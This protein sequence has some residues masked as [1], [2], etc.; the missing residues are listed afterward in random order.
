M[1]R[2]GGAATS[3]LP[4]STRPIWRAC[5]SPPTTIREASVRATSQRLRAGPPALNQMLSADGKRASG[6]SRQDPRRRSRSPS[7]SGAVSSADAASPS[8][9]R[10]DGIRVPPD[11]YSQAAK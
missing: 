1:V 10:R 3:G 5:P 11:K 4:R 7:V 2:V 8:G 9:T 6:G